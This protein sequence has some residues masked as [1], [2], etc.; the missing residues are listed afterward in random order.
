MRE[1]KSVISGSQSVRPD[2]PKFRRL[3]KVSKGFGQ[4]GFDAVV[5]WKGT[6]AIWKIFIGVNSQM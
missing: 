2:L 6:Y 1:R 5:V 4:R 3:G